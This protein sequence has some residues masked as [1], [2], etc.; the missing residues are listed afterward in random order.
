MANDNFNG[1]AT[2]ETL[3][4]LLRRTADPEK[5][6]AALSKA[7]G[8]PDKLRAL[9]DEQ[10]RSLR[11]N[12]RATA[13]LGRGLG[14]MFGPTGSKWAQLN[15]DLGG[16]G[17]ASTRAGGTLNKLGQL[18]TVV[19][20]L[21][22]IGWDRVTRVAEG[23]F[24]A[25]DTG[26][27]F[28]G[29]MHQFNQAVAD[30]G[31]DMNT[32]QKIITKNSAVVA[33]MGTKRFVELGKS[34]QAATN[35]GSALGM[36]ADE[37]VEYMGEYTDLLRRT[38]TLQYQS[39]QQLIDGTKAYV[40][41]LNQVAQITGKRREQIAAEAKAALAAQPT[42]YA[43]VN[44]LPGEIRDNLLKAIPQFQ[45][46][47]SMAGTMQEL[48]S[49]Y[50]SRGGSLSAVDPKITTAIIQSGAQPI[51]DQYVKALESGNTGLADEMGTRFAEVLDAW[52][53]STSMAGVF[54]SATQGSQEFAA[55]V[56]Q[57]ALLKRGM[58]PAAQGG[59]PEEIAPDA[60]KVMDTVARL[61]S[62]LAALNKQVNMAFISTAQMFIP[63]VDFA[64]DSAREL[65]GAFDS[66]LAKIGLVD[67][68][69]AM[70][71]E[72]GVLATG[73]AATGIIGSAALLNQTMKFIGGKLSTTVG[74]MLEKLGIDAP[75]LNNA[76]SRAEIRATT[77]NKFFGR[78]L[79]LMGAGTVAMETYNK[80]GSF[81]EAMGVGGGSLAGSEVGGRLGFRLG[82][83]T[84]SQRLAVLGALA[85]G[86]IGS[87]VG[88]E[89]I[90]Q[91]FG[92]NSS[93]DPTTAS[94]E[95]TDEQKA[96]QAQLQQMADQ[97][98]KRHETDKTLLEDLK[99]KLD[100]LITAIGDQTRTLGTAITRAGP[101]VR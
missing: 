51:L 33:N 72:G 9:L 78:A 15:D 69:G 90:E 84:G 46:F 24:D 12:T 34:L 83:L 61:D 64:A 47:G 95:M 40:V 73:M 80:T 5:L 60:A 6:I 4:E 49:R 74:P 19:A 39:N 65:S 48:V 77:L 82:E 44:K 93:S 98:Q 26:V 18:G 52:S 3:K 14:S 42:F 86:G 50:I 23:V 99:D 59:K 35:F 32:F 22:N 92:L 36:H 63:A 53:K 79:A 54:S 96:L 62:A 28:T 43:V 100:D 2:E 70:T 20:Q 8:D 76:A 31:V 56:A 58:L 11:D 85:G 75:G 13:D 101:D 38:N 30:L 81:T 94:G 21:A 45:K 16:L 25:Y 17:V 29:G 71:R 10:T 88:Q 66:L 1:W 67:E 57:E 41:Q 89:A 68:T 27:V 55:Q 37:I 7:A 91:L 87:V 97:T